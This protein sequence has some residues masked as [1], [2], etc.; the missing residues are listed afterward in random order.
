MSQ[1]ASRFEIEP[2]GSPPAHLDVVVGT[3]AHRHGFVRDVRNAG[4]HALELLVQRLP[5]LVERGDLIPEQPDSLLLLGG[6]NAF[7]PQFLDLGG[8]RVPARLQLLGFGDDKPPLPVELTKLVE[9]LDIAPGRKPL[10]NL[11]E[12]APEKMRDRACLSMLAH[13]WRAIVIVLDF[14]GFKIFGLEDL[15]A[16]PAF[17][18]IHAVSPGDHLGAGMVTSGLHNQRIECDLF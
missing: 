6:V 5:A 12:M 17:H 16:V 4:K 18:V 7:A 9:V 1:W 8:C 13:G 10:G 14:H 11:V 2:R 15:T 3:A